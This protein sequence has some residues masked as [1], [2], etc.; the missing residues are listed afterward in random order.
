M[1]LAVSEAVKGRDDDDYCS[2]C[3]IFAMQYLFALYN[4]AER[5]K[6]CLQDVFI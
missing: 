5:S 1:I 6:F 4:F 2:N 3:V